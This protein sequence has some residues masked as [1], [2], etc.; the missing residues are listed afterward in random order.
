MRKI[1]ATMLIFVLLK[2]EKDILPLKKDIKNI[3]VIGP[4][5]DHRLNQLGDYVSNVVL[6]DITTV[7]YGIRANAL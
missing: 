2:N 7:L 6:Q 5:A 3:A 4:N 1:K